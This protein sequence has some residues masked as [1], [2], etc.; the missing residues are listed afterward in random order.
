MGKQGMS[1]PIFPIRKTNYRLCRAYIVPRQRKLA[2]AS[3]A[4]HPAA[5]DPHQLETWRSPHVHGRKTGTFG[6][7]ECRLCR[8]LPEHS[9][10]PQAS[11]TNRRP[12][13]SKLFIA[14]SLSKN[15]GYFLGFP[16]PKSR[17]VGWRHKS[18]TLWT[19]GNSQPTN[20]TGKLI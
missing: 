3:L 15:E 1:D 10:P 6:K 7:T 17:R 11:N 5:G 14:K 13:D 8:A 9:I 2:G 19:S 12:G 18:F 20:K 16:R 4:H